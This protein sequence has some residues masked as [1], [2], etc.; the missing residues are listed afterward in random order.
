[1]KQ[2]PGEH[3]EDIFIRTENALRNF[4]VEIKLLK[5][6]ANR[7]EKKYTDVDKHTSEILIS[8][9]NNQILESLQQLWTEECR[10]EEEKSIGTWK[11]K[12]PWFDNYE[13]KYG[14]VDFLS[15]FLKNLRNMKS[16][17]IKNFQQ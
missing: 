12:Q 11:K 16:L 2:I 14:T 7:H 4:E 10:K 1:M 8:K 9:F 17:V 3:Q 15:Q 6:K 5:N 13:E